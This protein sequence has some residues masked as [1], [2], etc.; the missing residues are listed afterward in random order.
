[1]IIT[2]LVIINS[3]S[4]EYHYA[5]RWIIYWDIIQSLSTLKPNP[6]YTLRPNPRFTFLNKFYMSDLLFLF[7]F[8]TCDG[9]HSYIYF[10]NTFFILNAYVVSYTQR[11]P[12]KVVVRHFKTS[13]WTTT[14][15]ESIKGFELLNKRYTIYIAYWTIY[16]HIHR[17]RE[18]F[19]IQRR[20]AWSALGWLSPNYYAEYI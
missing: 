15:L 3:Y 20:L 18:R 2:S 19:P 6:L 7:H 5:A 10:P 11:E 9:V 14:S 17:E 16:N 13:K 8:S 1:M 4:N 12:I